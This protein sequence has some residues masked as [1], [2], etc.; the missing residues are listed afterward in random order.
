MF[1]HLA[2]STGNRRATAKDA[3]TVI[4]R[5]IS[6]VGLN[7]RRY[8]IA[9]GSGLSLYN[10]VSAELEVKWL[11]YGFRN[12]SM[13]RGLDPA[14]AAAGVDGTLRRR[15]RVPFTQSNVF[16]K[17]GT[18]KCISSLAGYCTAAKGHHLAFSIIN[19]G[20]MHHSNGRAF[21]DRVCTILCQP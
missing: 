21:Q 17:T 14:L 5:L 7:P 15:M 18:V 3:A 9:D 19:Q 16:A 11:R 8:Q 6:K 4:D 10:Y 2:A 1:Y 12:N 13:D 20:I